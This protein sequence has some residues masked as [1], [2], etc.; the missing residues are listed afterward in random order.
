MTENLTVIQHCGIEVID[1]RE[2]AEMTGKDHAHL[3]RDIGGYIEIMGKNP[4]LDSSNFFI[5]S[6]Y[7]QARNG[8]ENP[9]YLLTKKGCDMVAN[10]MTGEKGVLFTAA[11]VTA[12]EKMREHMSGTMSSLS[13]Q[14]QAMIN[15]ELRQNE[16]EQKIA[17]LEARSDHQEKKMEEVVEIFAVP[18]LDRDLWQQNMN[19]YIS[20]LCERYGLS[21]QAARGELYKELEL[22][23]GVNLSSRRTRMQNRMKRAGAKSAERQAV[24][25]LSVVAADKKL[26]PIFEGICRQ[27]AARLSARVIY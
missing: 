22:Q 16:Q 26:R 23:A 6:T 8:K 21:H 1:S 3:L 15:M 19:K 18:S 27:Y 24:T 20:S 17:A 14:L 25:K 2:V 13:P 7:R 10:K 12:F 4:K 5:Q 9:C 11:Y